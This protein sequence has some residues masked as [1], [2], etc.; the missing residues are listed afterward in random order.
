[1]YHSELGFPSYG[2]LG[3]GEEKRKIKTNCLNKLFIWVTS[4]TLTSIYT[5]I[6]KMNQE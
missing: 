3:G 6:W 4:N 2:K 5:V 1:M